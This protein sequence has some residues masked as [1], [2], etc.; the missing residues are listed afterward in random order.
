MYNIDK[1]YPVVY[2]R[3]ND[4]GSDDMRVIIDRFEGDIAVVE[5]DGET[6]NVPRALFPDAREGDTVELNN[7]GSL[8]GNDAERDSPRAIFA[9]LRRRR[10]SK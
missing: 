9:R 6:L 8:S 5:L 4:F 1:D 2:S 7:L 10:R 3:I